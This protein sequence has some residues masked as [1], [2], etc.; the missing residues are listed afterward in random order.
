MSERK[1]YRV[2]DVVEVAEGTV[3][4]RPDLTVRT[5]TGTQY[6]CDVPG[7]HQLGDREVTVKA[8]GD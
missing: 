3:V 1:N 5:F 6:V 4:T 7:T 8:A 2:G